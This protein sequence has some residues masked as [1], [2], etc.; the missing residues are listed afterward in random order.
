MDKD[1]KFS[2]YTPENIPTNSEQSELVDFLFSELDQYGDSKQAISKCLN[3][4]LKKSE[5]SLGGFVLLLKNSLQQ[6]VAGAILN[7]TGMSDYIPENI[8]VYI[9]VNKNC[10]GQG[11]GKK[12][13]QK[14]IATANG[15]I[16]LH[17]DAGNPAKKLYRKLGFTADY[18]EMRYIKK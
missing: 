8:L 17:V 13:I 4:A 3:F 5:N 1:F 16:A 6:I 11:I 18:L 15:N 2:L 14:I 7:K 12:M 10:R 9:A